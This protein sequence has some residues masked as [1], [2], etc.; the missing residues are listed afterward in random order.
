MR[1]CGSYS[2]SGQSAT[3]RCTSPVAWP[4]EADISKLVVAR[5]IA[6]RTGIAA[7]E[8]SDLPRAIE[9]LR[10]SELAPG[11]IAARYSRTNFVQYCVIAAHACKGCDVLS[12]GRRFLRHGAV[13]CAPKSH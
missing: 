2:V 12:K 4:A 8:C 13:T 9:L 5:D 1:P 3:M 10:R 6:G 11:V 7:C